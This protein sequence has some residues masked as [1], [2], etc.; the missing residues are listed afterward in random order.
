MSTNRK[1]TWK[2]L[3]S[4]NQEHNAHVAVRGKVYDISKFISKHPGGS[5]ILH[6]AAGKDITIP[7]ECYHTFSSLAPKT[8]ENYYVGDLVSSRKPTFPEPGPFYNTLRDRVQKYF[9]ETKQ[10]SKNSL[11]IWLRV[12]TAPTIVILMWFAQMFWLSHSFVL[13]AVAASVMGLCQ[14]M[15]SLLNFHDASH[16]SITRSPLVWRTICHLQ[17]FLNGIS[18]Y[19]WM[20]KHIFSH[21]PYTNVDGFDPDIDI[22]TSNPTTDI[23]RIKK[24]QIWMPRFFYQHIFAP[25]VY[26]MVNWILRVEDLGIFLIYKETSKTRLNPPSKFHWTLFVLGKLFFVLYQIVI[27]ALILGPWK[28]VALHMIGEMA[29]GYWISFLLQT[30]H[31]LSEVEW[32]IPD[33]DGKFHREWAEHQIA[34]TQDFS[35]ENSILSYFAG[36]TNHQVAHHLFP[37][38]NQIYYPDITPIVRETCKE[39]GIKYHCVETLMDSY[40][41][42]VA[43]L[44]KMGQEKAKLVDLQ[45]ED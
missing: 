45:H 38:I 7:F 33:K 3:A 41:G 6:M 43:Y 5:D 15:I 40:R 9:E 37:G 30:P 17:D 36:G 10:D 28:M 12:I 16:F 18:Y 29:G 23:R 39:F 24:S 13:S 42:H 11:W 35:T 14:S 4:L 21:H 32:P 34:T 26:F 27:P 44:K 20:H 2:E 25:S 19:V 1:F 8:L 22:M 31:V